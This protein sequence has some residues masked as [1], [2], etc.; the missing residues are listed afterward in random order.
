MKTQK[1]SI[2]IF[3]LLFLLL[4]TLW[5]ISIPILI[6]NEIRLAE[7]SIHSVEAFASAVSGISYTKKFIEIKFNN[8][9]TIKDVFLADFFSTST[10]ITEGTL[11]YSCKVGHYCVTYINKGSG[12]GHVSDIVFTEPVKRRKHTSADITDNSWEGYNLDTAE[13][14]GVVLDS[15]GAT[16]AKRTYKVEFISTKEKADNVQTTEN[17]G[18]IYAVYE[19][20][21]TK[22]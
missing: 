21:E 22:N 3:A 2:L 18:Q 9:D 5:G 7:D 10:S 8:P 13:I 20:K 19:I 12:Y 17:R 6:K 14:T 11:S 1:G 15:T 4:L 16:L